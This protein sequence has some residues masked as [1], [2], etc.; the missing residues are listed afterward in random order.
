MMC[1]DPANRLTIA[2]VLEHPWLAEDTENTSRVAVTM[3]P[4]APVNRNAKRAASSELIPMDD[5]SETSAMGS[6]SNGRPKRVKY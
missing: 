2:G 3:Q 5:G 1:V 6:M 4:A